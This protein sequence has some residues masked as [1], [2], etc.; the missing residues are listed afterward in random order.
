MKIPSLHKILLYPIHC[1]ENYRRCR[2]HHI[3]PHPIPF[4][5]RLKTERDVCQYISYRLLEHD[6]IEKLLHSISLDFDSTS[7]LTHISCAV[8]VAHHLSFHPN[9]AFSSVA[10]C[11]S[12]A[13]ER[14][15]FNKFSSHNRF[16]ADVIIKRNIKSNKKNATAKK[17]E[18][19]N[20]S[21]TK[22]KKSEPSLDI[23]NFPFKVLKVFPGS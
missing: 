18:N 23:I 19:I 1:N 14:F 4:E 11:H 10:L 7:V 20:F 17:K 12:A 5:F 16:S 3:F 15:K 2:H 9:E 21:M 13:D 8:K 22:H 6:L